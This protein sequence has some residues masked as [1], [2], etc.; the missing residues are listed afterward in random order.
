MWAYTGVMS[1]Q[2][3]T[4]LVVDSAFQGLGMFSSVPSPVTQ[5]FPVS[6]TNTWGGWD[7]ASGLMASF[8]LASNG[9]PGITYD[10]SV[11]GGNNHGSTTS[12][13]YPFTVGTGSNRL[14][15]VNLVGD[16][17]ADDINS[18][19]Y[20][21]APLTLLKEVQAAGN[22]RQYLY[23]LLNPASGSNNVVITA[24]TAHYLISEAASWYNVSQSAQPDALASNTAA[25]GITSVTTSLTTNAAGS[26]VVQGI[27]SYGHLEA[28]TGAAPIVIDA[29]IGG[30]ALFVSTGSPVSPAGSVSMT[31]LSDGTES[32][33]VIM[34]SFAPVAQ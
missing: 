9:T 21:G 2:G 16:I 5:A 17:Y 22:N 1:G 29:A 13:T 4:S 10:N 20:G 34:V 8:L 15:V 7:A 23:Y 6:M 26:L 27:W 30:A 12:L 31:T 11:D 19:T 18:V 14:L 25:A 33:G 32:S 3:S 24:A 28:G